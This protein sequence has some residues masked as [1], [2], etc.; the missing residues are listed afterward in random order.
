MKKEFDISEEYAK[1]RSQADEN[2]Y[3]LIGL[4]IMIIAAAL[5]WELFQ[6]IYRLVDPSR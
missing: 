1:E 2:K 5:D 3:F 4:T 6:W